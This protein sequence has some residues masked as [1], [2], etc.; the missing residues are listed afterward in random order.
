MFMYFK[1]ITL[2]ACLPEQITT[3]VTY[4]IASAR[5]DRA[6]LL[7]INISTDETCGVSYKKRYSSLIRH[8]KATKDSGRLQFFATDDSFAH[9]S[10]EAVFLYNKYSQ[11]FDSSKEHDQGEG[12]VYIKL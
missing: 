6:E 2:R 8:L 4:E 10:T 11:H 7:R 9:L 12:Y 3:E 1:E 5:A